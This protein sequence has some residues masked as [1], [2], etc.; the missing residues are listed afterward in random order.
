MAVVAGD[1]WAGAPVLATVVRSGVVESRHRG[2]VAGLAADGEAALTVGPV[3]APVFGRSANKPLQAVAALRAGAELDDEAI[4]LAAASHAGHPEQLAIVRRV[5]AGVRLD[6]DALANVDGWPLDEDEARALIR[7]GGGPSRLAHNCSGKH[8][9]MLAACVAR[10]W[11]TAGYTDPDHPL[12]RHITAGVAEL[13]AEPV[14]A[15]GVDGCGAP[16]HAVSLLGLA[17][18]FRRLASA[19]PATAEGRVAVAM[20]AHPELVGGWR[21]DVT[22]L[23]ADVPGL[24]AKDGAEGVYAAALPDGRAVALKIDD[25]AARARTPV[26]VAALAALGVDTAAVAD[27][28]TVPVLGGGQAVGDVRAAGL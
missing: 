13:A 22:R 11:P 16:V 2:A 18:A 24:V 20:R 28:A 17:R 25:G 6:E 15:I 9:A 4:A 12:Q 14:A 27:L 5:L 3:S 10:G 26:L 21:R 8:A 1:P 23:M 19:A 7:A